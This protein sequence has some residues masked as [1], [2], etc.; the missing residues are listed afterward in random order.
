MANK[1]RQAWK[2]RAGRIVASPLKA[3]FGVVQ[4]IL[5]A[6]F[7]LLNVL[8]KILG[9]VLKVWR[10]HQNFRE[11]VYGLPA[12]LV[13]VVVSVLLII[14]WEQSKEGLA[15]EYFRRAE[16]AMEQK[17]SGYARLCLERVVQLRGEDPAALLMLVEIY[18]SESNPRRVAALMRRVAP[19][20]RPT[21][22]EA[23][24]WRARSILAKGELTLEEVDEVEKQLENVLKLRPDD[25][26][27]LSLFGQ[28]L[29]QTGRYRQAIQMF[30]A[31]KRRLPQD[32]LRLAESAS[33]AGDSRL[34]QSAG[35]NALRMFQ[36]VMSQNP[37]SWQARLDVIRSLVFLERFEEAQDLFDEAPP[38]I[39]AD[40]LRAELSSFYGVWVTVALQQGIDISELIELIEQTLVVDPDSVP[41]LNAIAALL[42]TDDEVQLE[43]LRALLRRML[44]SGVA[45][46]LVHF[47]LGTDAVLRDRSDDA[48]VHLKLAYQADPSL[49]VAANNLAWAM[50]IADPPRLEEGL[51]L[52]N[53]VLERQPE[54][55]EV[56]DTRGQ[57]L[58]KLDRIDEAIVDLEYAL[59]FLPR[60]KVTRGA[61]IKAYRAIGQDVLAEEHELLL[62]QIEGPAPE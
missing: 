17:N 52:V 37:N 20:D 27:A 48:I 42:E 55:P 23:H 21:I 28:I 14:T 56:R 13:F 5:T 60:S 43:S 3:L 44:A 12:A 51:E 24:L 6:P 16:T 2:R 36:E 18:A 32:E 19:T 39:G 15:D 38:E 41:A 49:A 35:A 59:R 46:P 40:V 61:L 25:S 30:Q 8:W 29:M 10:T 33:F 11:F 58:L 47:C 4:W 7:S 9:R 54:Y 62:K 57:I 34:A 50:S 26:T 31:I 45:T 1:N 53:S 22:P